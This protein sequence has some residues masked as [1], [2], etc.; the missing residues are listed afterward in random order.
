MLNLGGNLGIIQWN[1]IRGNKR[2]RTILRKVIDVWMMCV[3]DKLI[4]ELNGKWMDGK[5]I[6]WMWKVDSGAVPDLTP[7]WRVNLNG[8]HSQSI[9]IL[10]KY[11]ICQ[12]VCRKNV[13]KDGNLVENNYLVIWV[14][15]QNFGWDYMNDANLGWEEKFRGI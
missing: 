5:W 13:V 11:T 6:E 2:I 14:G 8:P 7:R 10:I 9:I 3:C 4:N 1:K 12:K 15:N